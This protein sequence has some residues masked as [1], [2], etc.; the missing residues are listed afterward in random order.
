MDLIPV[1]RLPRRK[2]NC[3]Y[4]NINE[5]IHNFMRLNTKYVRIEYVPGEFANVYSAKSS[6]DRMVRLFDYPIQVAVINSEL[7]L[8]R[9]DMED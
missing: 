6:F 5:Y 2:A 1:T 8:V 3:Q 7:Y 4:K 9:V